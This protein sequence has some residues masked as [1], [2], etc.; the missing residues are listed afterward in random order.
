M[1]RDTITYVSDF[2]L[3]AGLARWGMMRLYFGD[4]SNVNSPPLWAEIQFPAWALDGGIVLIVLY[5]LVLLRDA[6]AECRTCIHL[7]RTALA[8]DMAVIVAANAGVLALLFSFTPFT[9]QVG[10]Q[11]WFLAGVLHGVSQLPRQEL[12]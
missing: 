1:L 11:Y 9:T 5:L 8:S 12:V 3:G 10:L 7:R 4:E 6:W 2:P